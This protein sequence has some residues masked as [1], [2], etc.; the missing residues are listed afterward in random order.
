MDEDT[1]RWLGQ[2][3]TRLHTDLDTPLVVIRW[4]TRSRKRATSEEPQVGRDFN[5]ESRTGFLVQ[6]HTALYVVT[7]GHVL[8]PFRELLAA[9]SPLVRIEVVALGP[10]GTTPRPVEIPREEVAVSIA[11]DQQLGLDYAAM[12]LPR[13][14][15]ISIIAA[16]GRALPR[17]AW[18]QAVSFPDHVLV[19]GFPRE[20]RRVTQLPSAGEQIRG[21]VESPRVVVPVGFFEESYDDPRRP[22]FRVKASSRT[23][24]PAD[25]EKLLASFNGLS[26]GPVVALETCPD[27]YNGSLIGIVSE[28]ND[29]T[30]IITAC[31]AAPFL[32]HL[33]RR[34]GHVL[35]HRARTPHRCPDS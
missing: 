28:A 25:D 8:A 3:Q 11:D 24:A 19:V 10:P 16:G 20:A 23:F 18:D 7:A 14:Q 13:A 26:G 4:I 29:A 31:H 22:M 35:D 1:R 34:L 32:T 30:G 15:A 33:E 27:G 17:S 2:N 12:A 9:G 6:V 21:V 5:I